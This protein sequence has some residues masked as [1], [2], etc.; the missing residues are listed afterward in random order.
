[1]HGSL[2]GQH[3]ARCPVRLWRPLGVRDQRLRQSS[4]R[5]RTP[6]MYLYFF[7]QVCTA[8]QSYYLTRRHLLLNNI[9]SVGNRNPL[10][11]LRTT[12]DTFMSWLYVI[13]SKEFE[14]HNQI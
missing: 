2:R 12:W 5:R 4:P 11:M 6:I 13:V 9:V 7:R 8:I 3:V 1:M 14:T 10:Q